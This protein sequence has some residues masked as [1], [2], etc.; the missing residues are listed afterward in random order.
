MGSEFTREEEIGTA[1]VDRTHVVILGAG[2]SVAACPDGDANGRRLPVMMDFVE[3]L[4]LK[5]ELNNAGVR[6]DGNFEDIYSALYGDSRFNDLRA[7]LESAVYE[8]FAGLAL[9]NFPTIYDHLVMSLRPKDVIATFNWDPFLCQA[10]ARNRSRAPLPRALF[11]HG[12]VAISFCAKDKKAFISC[13]ECSVCGSQTEPTRLLYPIRSKDYASDPFIDTQWRNLRAA[14]QNAFMLTVFGYG[15]PVSDSEAVRL[16]SGGWG[17]ASKRELEQTEIINVLTE[18]EVLRTWEPFIHTH[19]YEVKRSFYDS[20]LAKHPR[21]SGEA[22]WAQYLEAKF[23]E[24]NP[25]PADLS[26]DQFWEW[27]SALIANE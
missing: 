19:H 15:A 1:S 4:G 11:L 18:E 10:L 8:Y 20:W 22:W 12:N 21:R 5:G 23:I 25:L 13:R 26:F 2:A 6:S 24:Q 17:H 27:I 14:M 16:M 3:K 9:P 7:R